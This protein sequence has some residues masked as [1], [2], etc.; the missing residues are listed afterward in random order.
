MVNFYTLSESQWNT[1]I[2]NN[3]YNEDSLYFVSH[4]DGIGLY[5]GNSRIKD[6]GAMSATDPVGTGTF[7]M[8]GNIVIGEGYTLQIGKA[9]LSYNDTDKSLEVS[10]VE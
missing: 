7:T 4:S 8:N 6:P 2:A 1:A 9:I 5:K 3:T 10:F